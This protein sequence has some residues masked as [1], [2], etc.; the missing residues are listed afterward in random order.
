MLGWCGQRS[1]LLLTAC[2]SS[3]FRSPLLKL[4]ILLG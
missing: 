2:V 4:A 3:T 1:G